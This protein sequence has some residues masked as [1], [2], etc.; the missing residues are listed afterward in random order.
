MDKGLKVV[1]VNGIEE[2]YEILQSFE[3]DS[4]RK[5]ASVIIRDHDGTIKLYCKGADTIVKKR[6]STEVK[7]VFLPTIDEQIEQFS[8]K[9]L[10]TLLIAMRI[11]SNEE[12]GELDASITKVMDSPNREEKISNIKSA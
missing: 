4:N 12:Y 11:I 6:L 1:E 8:L 5:R 7:Q 3:F 9:G 2:K 10:R